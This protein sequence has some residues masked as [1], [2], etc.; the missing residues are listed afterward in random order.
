[1]GRSPTMG[2]ML[3]LD[4]ALAGG[5][6]G[7]LGGGAATG[8]VPRVVEGVTSAWEVTLTA[9]HRLGLED[10]SSCCRS[11]RLQQTS[12]STRLLTLVAASVAALFDASAWNGVGPGNCHGA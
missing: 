3:E 12:L 11:F 7:T 2:P 4:L 10:T 9:P 6:A 5:A 1:M 8:Q